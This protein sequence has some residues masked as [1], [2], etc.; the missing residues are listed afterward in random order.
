MFFY[1]HGVYFSCDY[2]V[3]FALCSS[4]LLKSYTGK[5][6]KES[7]SIRIMFSLDYSDSVG[8]DSSGDW[9]TLL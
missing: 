9:E 2:L 5:C 4:K 1:F 6:R 8:S 3:E 7:I